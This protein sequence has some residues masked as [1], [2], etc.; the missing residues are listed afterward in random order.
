MATVSVGD[1]MSDKLAGLYDDKSLGDA[2]ME[3][4]AENGP[5]WEDIVAFIET[6]TELPFADGWGVYWTTP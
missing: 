4:V 5:E 6:E 1:G 3:W 2:Y